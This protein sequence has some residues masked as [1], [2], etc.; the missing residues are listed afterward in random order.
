MR[1]PEPMPASR[2]SAWPGLAALALVV[3]GG[4][5]TP[6]PAPAPATPPHAPAVITAPAD[7]GP[8]I[9][10]NDDF[11]IVLAQRDDTP[12]TLAQRY[13]GDA[14]KAWWLDEVNGG[15]A[16]R[17]G[18][19][20]VVPLRERNPG[21]VLPGGY[22]TVPILCYH[23]FGAKASRMTV[24]GDAFQAQMDY[25]ARNGYQVITLGQLALFL[26]G[27]QAL[28]PKSVV[29]TIDD[30][31]RS[32]YEIAYPILRRHGFPATVFLYSDFAGAPDALSWAQMKSITGAGLVEIQPHS[33]THANLTQRL[34]GETEARYGER[35]R[36]EIDAP[37]AAIR[38]RLDVPSRT[39]AYP[40]G[41][42]NEAVIDLLLRQ[43]VRLGVTVTPGGNAFFAYPFMLRRTMVFGNE[44]LDAFRA[45]LTTF[46][47][48]PSR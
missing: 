43:Q 38:E 22:Q 39:Y 48:T 14:A 2:A 26:D 45:K 13:L 19:Y 1:R 16:P 6:A 29:I 18:Q 32:T 8:V 25:L 33:K 17:P 9:A 7:P 42:V 20:V 41:D 10:R 23:R 11:L 47:R 36:R 27:G 40:Y 46:V 15:A 24:T 30:G 37:I 12:A 3:L 21:G 31:Y 4:C 28:P 5:A 35:I 34:P 44:N